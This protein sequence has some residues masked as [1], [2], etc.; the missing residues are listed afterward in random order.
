MGCISSAPQITINSKHSS[1]N[2][3]KKNICSL[4][5]RTKYKRNKQFFNKTHQQN[6]TNIIDFLNFKELQEIGKTS[7][8]FNYLVKQDKVLIKFFKKKEP[9]SKPTSPQFNS[10]D[11][12][13]LK[14]QTFAMLSNLDSPNSDDN[15]NSFCST[16]LNTN[17]SLN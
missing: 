8:M 6:W 4:E 14:M 10:T 15:D 7:K 2:N 17:S 13:L 1:K 12:N 11:K 9:N 16:S 5:L 3:R